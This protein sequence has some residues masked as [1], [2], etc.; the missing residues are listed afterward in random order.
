MRAGPGPRFNAVMIRP[1]PIS[2]VWAAVF[3]MHE[4]SHINEMN[5]GRSFRGGQTEYNAYRLE[6]QALN[7]ATGGRFYELLDG[8]LDSLK[9][10][11]QKELVELVKSKDDR[12]AHAV[13]DL[14]EALSIATGA[15]LS[16]PELEM[17]HGLETM[18][19]VL[20]FYERRGLLKKAKLPRVYVLL[21]EI[22]AAVGMY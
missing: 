8:A 1:D 2:R 17:R 20:R 4:L 19:L 9:V 5:Q 21:E 16:R 13:L 10:K 12:A 6:T 15:A 18:A 7:L 3:L 11:S 14:D 22:L